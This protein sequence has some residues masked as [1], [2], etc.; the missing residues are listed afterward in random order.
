MMINHYNNSHKGHLPVRVLQHNII[1]QFESTTANFLSTTLDVIKNQG[2]KSEI[3][4]TVNRNA[5]NGEKVKGPFVYNCAKEI[6]IQ[7][8]FLAYLWCMTYSLYIYSDLLISEQ[9]NEKN[10]RRLLANNA[11]SYALSLIENY[12]DW[13]TVSIPNPE[14]YSPEHASDI[15]KTNELFLYGVNFI[16]CHEFS[17]VDLGH[18][19]A[20]TRGFL[21]DLEKKE[22]EMEADKQAIDLLV[23]GIFPQNESATKYGVAIALSSLLFFNSKVARKIHP[24][25]DVRIM[26]A[27]EQFSIEG[28]D[29]SWLIA[30]SALWLWSSNYS[31]EVTW[32]EKDSFS[33]LYKSLSRQ[34]N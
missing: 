4:Y 2:L 11:F 21:S 16:L 18:C 12:S 24:D 19:E 31:I 7:E 13:D 15:E 29:T 27:L 23:E 30:C 9:L 14:K 28:N 5:S 34:L 10:P 26:N 17:H 32:E 6:H 22:F 25:S 1:A 33:E 20:S 8:T 3:I